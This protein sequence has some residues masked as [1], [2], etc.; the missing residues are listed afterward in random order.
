MC[1][2]HADQLAMDLPGS[3][4][5]LLIALPVHL[6]PIKRSK[7]E[8]TFLAAF[9]VYTAVALFML[10]L[11]IN[12]LGDGVMFHIDMAALTCGSIPAKYR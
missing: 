7:G 4:L 3:D 9:A 11:G 6:A 1:T 12:L 2:N 10:V 5:L 8:L